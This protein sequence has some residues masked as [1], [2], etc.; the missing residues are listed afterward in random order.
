MGTPAEIACHFRIA[1]V[2]F[3]DGRGILKNRRAQNQSRS[4]NTLRWFHFTIRFAT[5]WSFSG[6]L[7]PDKLGHHLRPSAKQ[8]Q[9][10]FSVLA[11]A[12]LATMRPRTTEYY[13]SIGQPDAR[14]RQLV[15]FKP[16]EPWRTYGCRQRHRRWRIIRTDMLYG[17]SCGWAS[18]A[19][20]GQRCIRIHYAMDV[21]S[22]SIDWFLTTPRHD[23]S[24][25]RQKKLDL[26]LCTPA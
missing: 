5:L 22:C 7:S 10:F 26:R 25:P 17:V 20:V 4:F 12:F 3:V 6:L 8:S 9:H 18:P 15:L 21:T 11:M 13:L 23:P 2:S 14:S 24:G 1:G 19:R 16:V